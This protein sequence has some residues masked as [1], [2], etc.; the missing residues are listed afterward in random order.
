MCQHFQDGSAD[1]C[2]VPAMLIISARVTK[3][4]FTPSSIFP[5]HRLRSLQIYIN[6]S[7]EEQ[8]FDLLRME[9]T[10]NREVGVGYPVGRLEL[11]SGSS[12]PGILFWNLKLTT[13]RT[14]T[15]AHFCLHTATNLL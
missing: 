15:I 4:G 9:G 8:R 2:L 14:D 5:K 12:S 10:E 7:L 3:Y 11:A 13:H 6:G 1:V